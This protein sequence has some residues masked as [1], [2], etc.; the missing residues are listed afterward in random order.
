MRFLS[1]LALVIA[2]LATLS[3]A[4]DD[5]LIHLD[6][7]SFQGRYDTTYNLSYFRKIPFAAPPTGRNRFR[8]PQPPLRITNGTYNTDQTFDMC[9]QRTVN[10]TEDC[11][12]LGLFSRPW[13]TSRVMQRLPCRRLRSQF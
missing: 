1:A 11:L 6:Y 10:G 3:K 2:S 12:Y 13:D 4:Y 9:P 5:P 7:G 8:A